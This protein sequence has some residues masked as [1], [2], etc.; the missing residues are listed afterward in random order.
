MNTMDADPARPQAMLDRIDSLNPLLRAVIRTI[1]PSGA[2]RGTALRGAAFAVKDNIDVAGIP[3]TNGRPAAFASHPRGDSAVVARLRAAGAVPVAKTNL[4]EACLGATTENRHWGDCANPWDPTRVPGGSS[5]GSAVAVATG[6]C[7]F[8]LG[9]DT[10]GS[11]RNPAAFCGITGFRPTPGRVP[12]GGVAP[13]SRRYDAVGPMARTVVDVARVQAVLEDRPAELDHGT[14]RVGVPTDFF[15]GDLHPDVAAAMDTAHRTLRDLGANL[16]P[17]NLRDGAETPRT[18]AVL[19]QRHGA[20]EHL[21]DLLDAPDSFDRAV[22]TRLTAGL[23]VS[24][25]ELAAAER[26]AT[27]WS[28]QVL[29]TFDDVDLLVLPTVPEPAPP[30]SPGAMVEVTRRINRL[31]CAWSLAGVPAISVP[32]GVTRDGLPIGLQLVARPHADWA[33]LGF[34]ATYQEHTAWHLSAPILEVTS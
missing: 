23:A 12:M 2:G 25:R 31:N 20:G 29:D 9:T 15:Y 26:A 11:V 34:A 3:T 1:E 18:L 19:I 30:R 8:A 28:R 16:R 21:R 13:L 22:L 14:P 10:G 27:A 4:A 32:C 5:G 24:D 6:M 7:D 33:L 17:A